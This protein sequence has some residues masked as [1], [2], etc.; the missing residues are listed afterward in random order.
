MVAGGGDGVKF[1]RRVVEFVQLPP[2]LPFVLEEVDPVFDEID[3]DQEPDQLQQRV[4]DREQAVRQPGIDQL[5]H[6]IGEAEGEDQN[7]DA[8]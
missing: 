1:L 2:G 3:R 7:A 4:F 5:D 6:Q 8:A